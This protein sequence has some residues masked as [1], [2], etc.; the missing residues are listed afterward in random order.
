MPAPESPNFEIFPHAD[1]SDVDLSW[2]ESRVAKALP[3][4]LRSTGTEAPLLPDLEEVEISIVSDD[5]IA[6][7]HGQFMDDPTATD[8][9]TFHHG[10]IIVSI[11]TARREGPEHGHETAEEVL[12]YIVHGL[13][14]LSGHIDSAEPER[15]E[16]HRIQNR[17]VKQVLS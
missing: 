12:L 15:S 1:C 7:V 2:L 3:E 16:M 11:D 6:E 8:V 10:E 17:I 14:H 9:I 13:L 4:C 5:A